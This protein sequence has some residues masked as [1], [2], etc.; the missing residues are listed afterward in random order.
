MVVRALS[1]AVLVLARLLEG[2]RGAELQGVRLDE[3]RAQQGRGAVGLVAASCARRRPRPRHRPRR[4]LAAD[5][6]RLQLVHRVLA[7]PGWIRAVVSGATRL[8]CEGAYP[9]RSR[10]RVSSCS[11]AVS[12][13]SSTEL[14]LTTTLSGESRSIFLTTLTRCSRS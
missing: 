9:R 10:R 7:G 5:R 14:P 6:V 4:L 12:S 3:R 11:S 8:G 13:I 2:D 1:V